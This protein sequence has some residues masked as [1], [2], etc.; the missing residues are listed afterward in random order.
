[1]LD[2]VS[3]VLAGHAFRDLDREARSQ[4]RAWF[5]ADNVVVLPLRPPP[6]PQP[7][8][9]H[10]ARAPQHEEIVAFLDTLLAVTGDVQ[11]SSFLCSRGLDP[12][13]VAS[14]SLALSL[15]GNA[16]TPRWA[17]VA[18]R[19]WTEGWRL[20]LPAYAAD[21][22]VG[23]LRARWVHPGRPHSAPK[24]AAPVGEGA[25]RGF[26]LANEAARHLLTPE[27]PRGSA[28]RLVITEG[29]PDFLTWATAPSAPSLAIFGIW[30]GS[31]TP[32]IAARVP[33][34]SEVIVRVDNDP[35]GDRY[36]RA[37]WESLGHRCRVLRRV[38]PES[39]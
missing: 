8:A 15:P 32:E 3:H 6:A 5:G 31:W 37:I 21:G 7:R 19:P 27:A 4:V 13:A 1:V 18:G 9:P 2:L 30:S 26:V 29:E 16:S 34:G 17:R 28:V 23:S 24:S 12:V 14:S 10:G 38:P 22:R 20:I 39:A 33:S 36:A 11:V 35:A 25:A